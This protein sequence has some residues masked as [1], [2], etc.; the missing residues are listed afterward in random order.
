MMELVDPKHNVNYSRYQ[1]IGVSGEIVMVH[2]VL[3]TWVT[4]LAI[5]S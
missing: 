2:Y 4:K 3:Y 5:V 1:I